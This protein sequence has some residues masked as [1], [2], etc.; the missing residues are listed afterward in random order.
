MGESLPTVATTYGEQSG[1]L[2]YGDGRRELELE[3]TR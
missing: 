2:R 3:M 1:G